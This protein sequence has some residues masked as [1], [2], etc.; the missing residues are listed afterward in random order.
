MTGSAHIDTPMVL[1]E[2]AIN[3]YDFDGARTI[4]QEISIILQGEGKK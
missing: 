1:L 3:Q 2:K 4:L